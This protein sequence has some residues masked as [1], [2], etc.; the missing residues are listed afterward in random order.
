[1]D[2]RTWHIVTGD[3]PTLRFAAEEFIRLMQ[4]M[5]PQAPAA[6]CTPEDFPEEQVLFMGVS[7][8]S[9]EDPVIDDGFSIDVKNCAGRICGA[10]E[11]SIL[12]AVYRFFREAG[13]VFVRPGWEG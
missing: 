2:Q 9:V 11:R 1:M 7:D 13:C 3:H 8:F 6:V 12:L 4:K 10:N 5:D